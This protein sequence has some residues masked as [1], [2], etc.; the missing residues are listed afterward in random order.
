MKHVVYCDESR[1]EQNA[2]NPYMAIG[3]LW[4]P[5]D[6]KH[7]ISREFGAMCGG[8][9]VHAEVKWSKTSR[10]YLNAYKS[11]VDYFFDHPDLKY[12]VIVV[13]HQQNDPARFHGGDKELGFYKYYYEL[14]VK[15]IESGQEYLILL[16]FKQNKDARRYQMLKRVLD[17][18]LKGVAWID[19]LTVVDS[20]ETPLAQLCDLLTGATAAAWCGTTADS[21]KGRLI[22]HVESRRGRSLIDVSSSPKI[23]KFNLFKINLQQ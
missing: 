20:R 7:E 3:S 9:G 12:R 15:W 14:L 1:H 16:D 13:D 11:L 17:Q 6:R 10:L 4:M 5:R 18:K 19:D 22:Q 8:M 23:Q 2:R 21:P